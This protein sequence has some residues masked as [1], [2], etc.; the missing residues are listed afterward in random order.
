MNSNSKS[1]A[2]NNAQNTSESKTSFQVIRETIESIVI[3]FVLALTFRTYIAEA[4]MIPTGSMANELMGRHKDIY[5][6]GCGYRFKVGATEEVDRSSG[7]QIRGAYIT[8]VVC[9]NCRVG[10]DL[11]RE[12]I[13]G[14]KTPSYSGD[15]IIVGKY[16]YRMSKPD[17][18]DVFVFMFP[19]NTQTNYIKRLVG[20]PNETMRVQHGDVFTRPL[21]STEESD[22]QIARK[23]ADKI[24][25]V[26]Q[27]VYDD[28]KRNL[29]FY[30]KTN[31][32]RRWVAAQGSVWESEQDRS[33][34]RCQASSNDKINWLMYQHVV[35][36]YD[37]L[38]NYYQGSKPTRTPDVR[39]SLITDMNAYNFNRL[40]TGSSDPRQFSP[41][42]DQL[43]MHWTG[44]LIVE[45]D[46]APAAKTGK[47]YLQLIKG[48]VVFTA[49]INLANQTAQL[50]ISGENNWQPKASVKIE[51]GKKTSLRFANVDQ[52]LY[53]WVGGKLVSFDSPTQYN[54]LDN[55]LPAK[56]DLNPARIGLEGVAASVEHVKL[57]RDL[58]YIAAQRPIYRH[59]TD[60]E[61]GM[62]PYD[63]DSAEDMEDFFRNPTRWGRMASRRTIQFDLHDGQYFAMGDNCT[64]SEDSR[65]WGRPDEGI[66]F[67]VSEDLLIGKAQF[68][69]WPHAY[70]GFIPNVFDMRKVK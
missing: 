12:E 24:L 57:F 41:T 50:S 68:V 47:A 53:L 5:C 19:G 30:S 60:Y 62:L 43:G 14:Q 6:P 15:R 70:N 46:I 38:L 56:D 18:W 25:A 27:N 40:K 69:F 36:T 23:P 42:A 10:I 63:E 65:L 44:D 16:P 45:C 67:F 35:P 34:Y 58:Y 2:S 61:D 64:H 22:F 26:M 3:A 20:M 4:F 55:S 28:D 9:P 51:P 59:I 31:W 66:D 29:D 39:P 49:T 37:V 54:A 8:G 52:A 33:E 32:P 21:D 7:R 11:M 48:G 17:R 1:S 13:R